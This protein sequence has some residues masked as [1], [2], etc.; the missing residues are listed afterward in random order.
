MKIKGLYEVPIAYGIVKLSSNDINYIPLAYNFKNY[1]IKKNCTKN[2]FIEID[3]KYFGKEDELKKYQ[4]FIFSIQSSKIDF[5]YSV[6]IEEIKDKKGRMSWWAIL[7]IVVF[8][9]LIFFALLIIVLI[10]KKKR[11]INIENIKD[12]QPLYPNRK[13]IL[14]DIMNE[15]E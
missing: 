4:A 7:L 10:I 1:I 13:Y 14:N 5:K 15:T 6:Q 8:S 2:E 12:N 9:I 3:N 11:G